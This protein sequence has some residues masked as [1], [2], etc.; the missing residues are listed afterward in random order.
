MM[1]D[2]R[3]PVRA[4]LFDL[5]KVLVELGNP[6]VLLQLAGVPEPGTFLRRWRALDDYECGRIDSTGFAESAL[7]DLGLSMSREEFLERFTGVVVGVYPGAVEL[8][9]R[10]REGCRA[11]CLSNTCAVHWERLERDLEFL[12][13][14]DVAVG[15]H[16][17]GVRKPDARAYEQ[18]VSAL[19]VPRHNILFLDDSER[20]VQAATELGL[21]ARRTHGIREV[22][23]VLIEEGVIPAESLAGKPV[24]GV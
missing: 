24:P 10:V 20:N 23:N 22:R 21:R 18:A 13:H 15:S 1:R 4:V 17:I 2:T 14:F 9:E 7:R 3:P 16:Q 19:G 5:G 11:G 12:T 6:L 8:L